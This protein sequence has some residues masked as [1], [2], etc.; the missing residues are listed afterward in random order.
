MEF[1][2]QAEFVELD[3]VLKAMGLVASELRFPPQADV[4]IFPHCGEKIKINL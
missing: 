3:N 2:L 4:G 1:K